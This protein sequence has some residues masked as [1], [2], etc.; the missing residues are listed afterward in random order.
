VAFRLPDVAAAGGNK[1][2]D[3]SPTRDFPDMED[4]KRIAVVLNASDFL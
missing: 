4:H 1:P 2:A 3:L